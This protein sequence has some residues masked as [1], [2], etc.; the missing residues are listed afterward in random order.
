MDP[1]SL[2][3]V[4]SLIAAGIVALAGLA[5]RRHFLLVA[6]AREV[7]WQ[8]ERLGRFQQVIRE[9]AETRAFEGPM[10]F[11]GYRHNG[12]SRFA[13]LVQQALYCAPSVH[14]RLA[15][16]DDRVQEIEAQFEKFVRV[17]SYDPDT[18]A[19]IR[20][21]AQY[22]SGIAAQIF[23]ACDVVLT[24]TANRNIAAFPITYRIEHMDP[25]LVQPLSAVYSTPVLLLPE[26]DSQQEPKKQALSQPVIDV[27]PLPQRAADRDQP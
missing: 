5:I 9:V 2:T 17:L 8:R 3:I 24:A 11:G 6:L 27:K 14:A 26:H 21:S 13:G 15:V 10:V 20:L 19:E 25:H 16:F 22:L 12:N 23:G 4:G 7:D 1:L 18:E